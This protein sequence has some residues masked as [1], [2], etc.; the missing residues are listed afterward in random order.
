MRIKDVVD[1]NGQTHFRLLL[2]RVAQFQIG[3]NIARASDYIGLTLLVRHIAPHNPAWPIRAFGRSDSRRSWAS[4]CHWAIS[5][6][7]H[8]ARRQRARS[9]LRT[10]PGMYLHGGLRQPQK[11]QR[12]TPSRVLLSGAFRRIGR[13]LGQCRS[14]PLRALGMSV[15]HVSQSRPK[16]T[17][18]RPERAVF[19]SSYYSS[20]GIYCQ[21]KSSPRNSRHLDPGTHLISSPG[22]RNN[23][24]F[25]GR[26]LGATWAQ[27]HLSL[28]PK[29]DVARGKAK[30]F[31]GT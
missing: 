12:P 14:R 7:M 5:S 16:T 28:G 1:S 9:G 18:F 29:S 26:N 17:A 23:G 2:F 27:N 25:C 11:S 4:L 19:S 13:C 30:G 15:S 22:A 21:W 8:G 31:N 20:S 24:V 10:R 3:K 6:G